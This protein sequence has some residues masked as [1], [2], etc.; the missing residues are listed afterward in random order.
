[1]LAVAAKTGGILIGAFDERGAIGGFVFSVPGLPDGR[2]MQWS[3]MLGV[4]PVLRG[5]GV[6]HQLKLA[7]RER[8]LGM[9]L[10]LVEWTYDPLLV[11]NAYLNVQRLGCV[12]DRYVE[13]IYG[14]STSPLHRGSPTDRFIASW[15]IASPH[16]QRRVA[17]DPGEGA[18]VGTPI[19][20]RDAS[21]RETPSVLET[22][23]AG[24]F[25]VPVGPPRLDLDASRL[26]VEIPPR[27]LEMLATTGDLALEW[28]LT[29]RAIFQTLFARGYR[30]VDFQSDR[31]SGRAGYLLRR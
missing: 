4:L 8:A 16:V 14:A 28:R 18:A 5:R 13:N 23:E 9:A 27:Y 3:H 31:H 21:V 2:P 26:F 24:G 15:H 1:M 25:R 10:D 22:R 6:G 17:A 20:L 19:V 30:V 7:Q 11:T 12:V 29:S